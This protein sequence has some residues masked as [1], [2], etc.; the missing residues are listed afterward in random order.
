MSDY[1]TLEELWSQGRDFRV[2]LQGGFSSDS[3]SFSLIF[4]YK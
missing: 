2:S 3:Y 4:V 1:P